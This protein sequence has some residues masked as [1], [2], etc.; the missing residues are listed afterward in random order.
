M[1]LQTGN[2][3]FFAAWK[4]MSSF[5]SVPFHFFYA[6]VPYSFFIKNIILG[7]ANLNMLGII[8]IQ[9]CY[10][11]LQGKRMRAN[12]KLAYVQHIPLKIAN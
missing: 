2:Y 5:L 9:F 6:G 10:L 3:P 11:A 4:N 12:I 1:Q 7:H 8:N